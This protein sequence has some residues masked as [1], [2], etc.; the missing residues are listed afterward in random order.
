MATA[1]SLKRWAKRGDLVAAD[2]WNA[3][4]EITGTPTARALGELFEATGD[5][6]GQG[7]SP[8]A[9]MT[10]RA[11]K[12]GTNSGLCGPTCPRSRKPRVRPSPKWVSQTGP[13]WPV[14]PTIRARR[15]RPCRRV[16]GMKK[17]PTI[18]VPDDDV[19]FDLARLRL[20]KLRLRALTWPWRLADQ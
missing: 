2:H 10:A 6:V 15:K 5:A 4:S 14:L 18:H 8:I 19:R 9:I 7:R 12:S 20:K 1:A 11:I 13:C 3:V 17:N 16:A